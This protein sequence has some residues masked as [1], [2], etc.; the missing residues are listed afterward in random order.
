MYQHMLLYITTGVLFLM[1]YL[2]TPKKKNLW[3]NVLSE[4]DHLV[5]YGHFL[6]P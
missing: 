4:N 6:Q 1:H 3:K 2:Y 5:L